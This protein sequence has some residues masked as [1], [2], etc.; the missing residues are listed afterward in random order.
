MRQELA[1]SLRRADEGAP[2]AFPLKSLD[3]VDELAA[4]LWN[5]RYRCWVPHDRSEARICPIGDPDADRTIVVLGDSH[6][7]QWL[8]AFDAIGKDLGYRVVP[9][10][11]FGCVPYDVP[12]VTDDLT[13]PYTECEDFRTW[14]LAKIPELDPDV[15]YVGSRT[16]PGNL[17]ASEEERAQVW[18][19]GVASTVAVLR[20]STPDVRL[21]ADTTRLDFEPIE[22]LTDVHATMATCTADELTVVREANELT[23]LAARDGGAAYIEITPLVCLDQR[24]PAFAGGRMVFTNYDHLSID[25]VEH[26]L[27]DLAKVRNALPSA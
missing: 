13:R 21:L 8:P 18:S 27:P 6:A 1:V 25:W 26:V 7:G 14:V 11:K 23:R 20:E 22:C 2:V 4:D 15:V 12:L 16:M 17:V 9:L 10:I 24:C 19:D 5:F 3:E